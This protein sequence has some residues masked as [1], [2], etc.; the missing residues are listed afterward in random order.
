[1]TKLFPFC[2]T[3]RGFLGA[4]A[5]TAGATAFNGLLSSLAL[6][7]GTKELVWAK[8][9]ETTQ[10]DPHTS[11]LGSSWQLLHLVYSSLVDVDGE[12]KPI[13]ALAE[14]W[15]EESPTSHVFKLRDGVKFSDGSPL[16]VDDVIGSIMRV[17]DPKTGSFWQRPIGPISGC[18]AVDGNRV[19][20]HLETPHAP[21]L[22]ALAATMASILPMHKL[23]DASFDP[24]K[25]M[26]GTGPFMVAEHVQD[27]HWILERNP[28]YWQEGLPHIERITI[29]IVPNDNARIA[30]LSDGSVDVAS[31]EAS[32]DA[33]LLLQNVP[34][35]DVRVETSTN[36]YFL[37]LNAVSENSPFTS[38]KLRQAVALSL[39]REQIKDIALGGVGDPTA[40]MA[41]AFKA[42][43]TGVLP[44]FNHDLERAK[45]LVAE[46]GAEGKTFELLVRNIPADIQM[47]QV[48]KQGV[49]E[50]GLDASIAVVDEGIWVKRAWVD[51]PSEFQAMISWYAGYADPAIA[52][53]WWNPE[54]AGFTAGH[55]KDNPQI[56]QLIE[57]AYQTSGEQRRAVLQELCSAIDA[58]A[59]VI[60]LVTRQDTIAVRSGRLLGLTK[61][62]EGYVHTLR[63]IEDAELR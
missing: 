46:A 49:S 21:L 9:L 34:G 59:N 63:G 17:R 62:I 7:E 10:L 58:S 50:I 28:H 31:F 1:M 19:R 16:T 11:I 39:D 36:Y 23:R 51:N 52:T 27:D 47:A 54:L 56:N 33:P 60:P 37:G 43:D 25:A 5:A 2:L 53:L 38:D 14:S 32:P 35:L 24:T 45:A 20:L 44:F 41:P 55:V 15:T 4:T 12:L 13:P 8:P 6:A 40:A 48:I 22:P 3:R 61:Q 30:M 26:L 29:R 42:C 57:K 18:E